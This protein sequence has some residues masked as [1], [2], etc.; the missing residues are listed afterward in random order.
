MAPNFERFAPTPWPI[1]SL[2]SS[3][4]KPFSSVLAF[5][6]LRRSSRQF[7]RKRR[8]SYLPWTGMSGKA[9]SRRKFAI[10][11]FDE[12]RRRSWYDC[13]NYKILSEDVPNRC[14]GKTKPK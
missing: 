1:A 12:V 8:N 6:C 14:F 11:A 4:I 13:M 10:R 7:C 5:S 9:L 3:G 2:A